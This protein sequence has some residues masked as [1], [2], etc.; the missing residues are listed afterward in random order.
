MRKNLYGD[1]NSDCSPETRNDKIPF[2]NQESNEEKENTKAVTESSESVNHKYGSISNRIIENYVQTNSSICSDKKKLK[3]VFIKEDGNYFLGFENSHRQISFLGK[4]F[5][6]VNDRNLNQKLDEFL[7]RESVINKGTFRD[8]EFSIEAIVEKYSTY[9]EENSNSLSMSNNLS[10]SDLIKYNTENNSGHSN[11]KNG[12]QASNPSVEISTGTNSFKFFVISNIFIY[13]FEYHFTNK[14]L[15]LRR[16][17]NVLSIDFFSITPDL[18]KLI[19]HVNSILDGGGNLFI[20]NE[21]SIH[22]CF[23]ICNILFYCYSTAKN[24]VV[25]PKSQFFYKK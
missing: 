1:N 8:I 10:I 5:R 12:S 13:D 3:N 2:P 20:N 14:S 7:E 9:K 4:S 21:N 15:V 16:K 19:I 22:I 17:I 18:K 23:C 24:L 11:K 6:S 25:I